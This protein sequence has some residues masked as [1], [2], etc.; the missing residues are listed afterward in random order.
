MNLIP[1]CRN[2]NPSLSFRSNIGRY[3][4]LIQAERLDPKTDLS[5][6][7]V[8]K[9]SRLLSRPPPLPIAREWDAVHQ[10]LGGQRIHSRPGQ[11]NDARCAGSRKPSD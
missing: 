11:V 7:A 3:K 8:P 5:Y 9:I 2:E 6:K 4:P 1:S 10:G